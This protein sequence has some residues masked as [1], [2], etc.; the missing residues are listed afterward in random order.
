MVVPTDE[1]VTTPEPEPTVATAVLLLVQTPGVEASL[2]VV[3]RPEQTEVLPRMPAGK[4]LTVTVLTA[5][6]PPVSA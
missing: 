5:V 6:H 1:P 3:D 2:N 4:G